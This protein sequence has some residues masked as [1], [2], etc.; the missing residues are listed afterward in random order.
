MLSRRMPRP[1]AGLDVNPLVVR[2]AMPDDLAH[3][4]HER[5]IGVPSRG[6]GEVVPF[7][8]GE[9]CDSTHMF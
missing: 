5:D 2:P 8:V 9:A 1:D 6:R 4:V 3:A 7:S